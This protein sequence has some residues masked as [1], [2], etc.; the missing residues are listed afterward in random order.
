MSERLNKVLEEIKRL[1]QVAVG[2]DE[3]RAMKAARQLHDFLIPQLPWPQDFQAARVIHDRAQRPGVKTIAGEDMMLAVL[4][5][6]GINNEFDEFLKSASVE[7]ETLGEVAEEFAKKPIVD[8]GDIK[9]ISRFAVSPD[10][11][12]SLRAVR[13]ID[14][15]I[16]E[17]PDERD[18]LAALMAI[19]SALDERGNREALA[20]VNSVH[21]RLIDRIA[22]PENEIAKFLT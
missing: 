15:R 4:T 2:P 13:L 20:V 16:G 22:P 11:T 6:V 1:S 5:A 19:G 9:R 7:A 21:S 14:R 17:L 3:D 18:I 10:E 8:L 12:I